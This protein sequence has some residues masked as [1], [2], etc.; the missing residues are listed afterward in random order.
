MGNPK[1]HEGYW[2]AE[3]FKSILDK[4]GVGYRELAEI[5]DISVPSITSYANN[6]AIPGLPTAI[7]MADYFGVPLDVFCG[8]ISEEDM[9]KVMQDFKTNFMLL[10]RFDYEASYLRRKDIPYQYERSKRSDFVEAPYP[11]NLLDD[12]VTGIGYGPHDKKY[13]DDMLEPDQ[14]AAL[15]YVLSQMT[16]RERNL[17]QLYYGKNMTLEQCGKTV[18]VTRERCRQ[19]IAKAVRKLRHPTRLN[20]IL[21]GLEGYEHLR[22]NKK[23][24]AMLEIEDDELD[25]LE[26]ELMFRRQF[27]ESALEVVSP[28]D[29]Q[30]RKSAVTT[31]EDMDLSVRTFNC[32]RRA[33]CT[34]LLD[35][36]EATK[37]GKLVK[38]RNLGK[39]SINEVLCKVK[40]MTGVDYRYVY[41]KEAG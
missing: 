37:E 15:S 21:Y 6:R 36:V 28:V 38:V 1:R 10:R 11:Y 26:Q 8:R 23:R 40:D 4:S 16:D 13:W 22:A 18:G 20:L 29:E 32:L 31:L 41:A 5:L 35:V 24:R 7:K 17:I 25:A 9:Q 39:K 30:M 33:N 34:T 12:V 27:L 3:S 2:D 14:E 19:I